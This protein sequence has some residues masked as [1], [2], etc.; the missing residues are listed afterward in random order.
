MAG[1][2]RVIA[3]LEKYRNGVKSRAKSGMRQMAALIT[4]DVYNI[5]PWDYYTY[6]MVTSTVAFFAGDKIIEGLAGNHPLPYESRNPPWTPVVSVKRGRKA[7]I[8]EASYKRNWEF[9]GNQEVTTPELA[10]LF[11]GA[12]NYFQKVIEKYSDAPGGYVRERLKR[13]V[14][15]HYGILITEMRR[16]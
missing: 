6:N 8:S 11:T 14:N 16:G 9:V 15:R 12:M 4:R 1:G 10:I 3:N 7:W 5:S 13:G 2:D